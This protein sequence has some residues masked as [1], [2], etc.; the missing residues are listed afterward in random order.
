MTDRQLPLSPILCFANYLFPGF[1]PVYGNIVEELWKFDGDIVEI[2]EM[3]TAA[4]HANRRS[5]K[6]IVQV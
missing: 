5:L 4:G 3:E 2:E 6:R 1:P